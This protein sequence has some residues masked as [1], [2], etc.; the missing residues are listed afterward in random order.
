MLI[1]GFLRRLGRGPWRAPGGARAAASF[2]AVLAA[3]VIAAVVATSPLAAQ[4][5]LKFTLDQRFDALSTPYLVALDRGYLKDEGLEVAIDPAAGPAEA[6]ERVASGTYDI[7]VADLGTL[8][9]WRDQ[10]P[11]A[12][13]PA[14]FM[15]FDR[16]PYAILA[17][18]SRGIA[19]PRDLDGKRV[20]ASPLDGSLGRLIV[21]ARVNDID[22]ARLKVESVAL[23]V[24]EP[25]LAAGQLDAISATTF[26]VLDLEA[27]G[28]PVD[29]VLAIPMAE[30]GVELYGRA[31]FVGKT[32]AARPDA[33]RAFLRA[34]VKGLTDTVRDP[35]QAVETVG[36]R[37]DAR[38]P[39]LEL[40]RLRMA[41]RQNIVTPAVRANGFGA[42]D[43]ERLGRAIAQ[44]GLAYQFRTV[45]KPAE[46]FDASFLPPPE[47]RMPPQETP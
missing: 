7:G 32:L 41:V 33:V 17:R 31:I 2:L 16:P 21:F 15:V 9:R 45:P 5:F 23:P 4:P 46:V 27:R 20:G 34:I 26:T 38:A 39:A 28:V 30:H 42:V 13:L 47:Q 25:M 37:L 8:I 24:R 18:R 6:I 14:V 44:L 36:K 12:V 35:A 22:P 43:M 10:H 19:G 11:E 3:V 29:D 1:R 40:E